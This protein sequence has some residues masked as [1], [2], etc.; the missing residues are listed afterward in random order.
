M[1]VQR[2]LCK[3]SCVGLL[4]ML[5][6]AVQFWCFLMTVSLVSSTILN[7]PFRFDHILVI[8]PNL[9]TKL[10]NLF[11]SECVSKGALEGDRLEYIGDNPDTVI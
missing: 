10:I 2:V 8:N 1:H 3:F 7:C 5:N 6:D 9:W 4:I 11:S